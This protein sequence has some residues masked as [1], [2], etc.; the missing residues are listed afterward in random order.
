VFAN[1]T[2]EVA[3]VPEVVE[4]DCIHW[5]SHEVASGIDVPHWFIKQEGA[6]E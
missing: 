1:N 4:I 6:D 5:L 2:E 3:A